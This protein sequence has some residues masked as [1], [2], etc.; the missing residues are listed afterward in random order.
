[1]NSITSKKIPQTTRS[2][3]T[4]SLIAIAVSSMVF[5][6]A[7]GSMDIESTEKIE[8]ADS[9]YIDDSMP[10]WNAERTKTG[11]AHILA[12]EII[13]DEDAKEITATK[14]SMN[15]SPKEI[16]AQNSEFIQDGKS[17]YKKVNSGDIGW[18][19]ETVA[20]AGVY[21]QINEDTDL[22]EFYQYTADGNTDFK[23]VSKDG[24]TKF[25]RLYFMEV[26]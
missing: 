22:I 6:I 9:S 26:P 3:L 12:L 1:M 8:V 15:L 5:A 7:I 17:V 20:N 21:V 14:Y 13:P 2:L 10:I 16:Q 11:F 24:S 4:V 23:I 19:D 25:Y 18:L